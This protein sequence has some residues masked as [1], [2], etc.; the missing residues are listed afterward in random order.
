MIAGIGSAI[1]GSSLNNDIEAQLESVFSNGSAN[2]GDTWLY[3]GIAAA[4]IGLVLVVVSIIK[5]K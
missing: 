1:Y 3:V 5:K 2:P 4:V